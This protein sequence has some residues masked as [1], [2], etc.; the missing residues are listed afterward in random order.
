MNFKN[1]ACNRNNWKNIY[2][3]TKIFSSSQTL[4]FSKH[5]F[6]ESELKRYYGKS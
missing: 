1:A 5:L 4:L 2:K 6:S 3:I